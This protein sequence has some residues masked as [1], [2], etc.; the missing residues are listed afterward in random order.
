MAAM[1]KRKALTTVDKLRAVIEAS[2]K[3]QTK[4]AESIGVHVRTLRGWLY[5]NRA[6]P[7]M[8]VH[9]IDCLYLTKK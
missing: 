7:P 3:S 2:G 9:F 5:G 8:V 4:F 6:V 1:P